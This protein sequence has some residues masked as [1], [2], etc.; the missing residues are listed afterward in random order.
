MKWH[1]H[2]S[3]DGGGFTF[4]YAAGDL[5]AAAEEAAARLEAAARRAGHDLANLRTAQ[6]LIEVAA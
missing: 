5:V 3:Y 1:V 4:D 2:V 6:I